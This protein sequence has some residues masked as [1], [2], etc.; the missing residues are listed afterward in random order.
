MHSFYQEVVCFIGFKCSSCQADQER[1]FLTAASSNTFSW[2]E[3]FLVSCTLLQDWASWSVN[4]WYQS[5][6]WNHTLNSWISCKKRKSN[7]WTYPVW[8]LVACYSYMAKGWYI[9]F[10]AEDRISLSTGL[11]MGTRASSLR[12]EQFFFFFFFQV[13]IVAPDLAA[14]LIEGF[15]HHPSN[16]LRSNKLF[17][18]SSWFWSTY[19]K[20]S[21]GIGIGFAKFFPASDFAPACSGYWWQ[22]HKWPNCIISSLAVFQ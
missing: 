18:L 22:C 3:I 11:Y 17:L 7:A 6:R 8:S 5:A 4:L 1:S 9:F 12:Q 10:P 15:H 13:V 21:Y 2:T 19:L 20:L 16:V 14:D